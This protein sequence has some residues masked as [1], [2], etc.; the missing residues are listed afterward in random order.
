MRVFKIMSKNARSFKMTVGISTQQFDLLM[1]NV[2]KAYLE[3]EFVRLDRPDRKL[4]VGAYRRFSPRYPGQGLPVIMYYRT[5][6]TRDG[7]AHLF[8]D[9][10]GSISTNV[11]KMYP[12]MRS[13]LPIPQKIHKQTCKATTMDDMN[14]IFRGCSP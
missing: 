12:L 4:R 5:Y 10:P 6:L 3:A 8:G 13:R 14:E 9:H 11:S 2:E 1:Y 7:M